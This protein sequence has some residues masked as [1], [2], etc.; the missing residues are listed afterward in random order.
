[1]CVCVHACVRVCTC[2]LS[3]FLSVSLTIHLSVFVPVL[4]VFQFSQSI[5]L[6]HYVWY[7]LQAREE[8][9][10]EREKNEQNLA[11]KIQL[12]EVWAFTITYCSHTM[13]TMSLEHILCSTNLII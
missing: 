4:S 6:C 2:C 8:L 12:T 7:S 3:L 5:S 11:D 10:A 9:T 13:Q 1:M